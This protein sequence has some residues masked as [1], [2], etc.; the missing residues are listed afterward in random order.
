MEPLQLELSAASGSQKLVRMLWGFSSPNDRLFN[1]DP[2]SQLSHSAYRE[3]YERQWGLMA[4]HCDG[5]FVALKTPEAV[6]ELVQELQSN[7]P[8]EEL[9]ALIHDRSP[10]HCLEDAREN[11]LNLA[12]RLLLMLRMGAIKYQHCPRRCLV[13][14]K[15][16]PRD[17]LNQRFCEGPILN[18]DGVKLPKAFN[19]WSLESIGGIEISFT[20]NLADHL[21]LIEDDSKVLVFHYASFLDC[22]RLKG[23]ES[24]FPTTFAEETLRTLSLLFPQSMVSGSHRSRVSRSSWFRKLCDKRSIYKIDERLGCCGNLHA[25]DRQIKNFTFWRDRL[26]ILKQVYDEATPMTLSQFWYDR[27]NG[28]QWYTFWVAILVLIIT[29][30]FAVLQCVQGGF[31]TWK[32]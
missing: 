31:Q 32:T 6:N 28:V 18:S 14:D 25:E 3:Y 5:K 24:L 4:A 27:R 1:G 16:L 8:H 29:T 20:D 21:L 19:G 12:V 9:L 23:K 7:R 10:E 13:W 26:V 17:F 30:I 22:Q 11:S 2:V 15:G